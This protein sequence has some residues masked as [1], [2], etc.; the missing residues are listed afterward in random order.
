MDYFFGNGTYCRNSFIAKPAWLSIPINSYVS[1]TIILLTVFVNGLSIIVLLYG[2]L[3]SLTSCILACI[4]AADTITGLF[5]LPYFFSFY[6]MGNYN[7]PVSGVWCRLHGPFVEKIPMIF[8]TLSIWLNV[9]L[10]AHRYVGVTPFMTKVRFLSTKSGLIATFCVLSIFSILS[11][12]CRFFDQE[13]RY[14]ENSNYSNETYCCISWS[15]W[16]KD[17]KIYF[18]LYYLYRA[19]VLQALPCLMLI[20]FKILLIRTIIDGQIEQSQLLHTDNNSQEAKRLKRTIRTTAMLL[21]VLMVFLLVELPKTL[22]LLIAGIQDASKIHIIDRDVLLQ[23]TFII[24]TLILFSYPIN[25]LIYCL[26]SREFRKVTLKL[27]KAFFLQFIPGKSKGKNAST[28]MNSL[29]RIRSSKL[30]KVSEG[31]YQERSQYNSNKIVLQKRSI[32]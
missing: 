8:H 11:H 2:K 5:P 16:I 15:S 3:R 32:I 21:I 7:I 29:K 23:W 26:M 18:N 22:L 6:L 4:A 14:Y 17:F 25:F 30:T 12:L 1:P 9:L 19:I 24:N 31:I 13:L 10:A 27:L 20:V 28:R